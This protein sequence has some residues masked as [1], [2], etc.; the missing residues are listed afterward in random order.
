M[1]RAETRRIMSDRLVGDTGG[2]VT[3]MTRNTGGESISGR[4]GMTDELMGDIHDDLRPR[5]AGRPNEFNMYVLESK[6]EKRD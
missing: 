5:G 6:F 2:T 3:R 4:H 1:A